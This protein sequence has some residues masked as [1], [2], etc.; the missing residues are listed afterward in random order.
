MSS[1][2]DHQLFSAHEHA[3]EH[4]TCPKCQ[5]EQRHGEL[6]LRHGKHGPFLGCDQ[7]P[8]CDF[9]KPL[10]QNDGHI[11]KELGIPC[12][13]CASELVLRQGRYGMFIGCSNYPQCHHIESL[14]QPEDDQEAPSIFCPE[15][16]KGQLVERK[17]RFGKLFYACDNYPKCKFAV[18]QPPVAGKC[19]KCGYPLLIEKKSASSK[20][21]C[22]DRKCHHVQ[23]EN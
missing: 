4:Q 7:Y 2:I 12:P 20:Y 9:I 8:L 19:E 5:S 3:L 13:E 18:N 14:D 23:E 11:I 15:C 1:K 21:Q 16:A 22:A 17:T 6:H 10:H